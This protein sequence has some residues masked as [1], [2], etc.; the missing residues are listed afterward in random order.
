M[1][2]ISHLRTGRWLNAWTAA[3]YSFFV[4]GIASVPGAGPI[5]RVPNTTLHLPQTPPIF[6][7]AVTNAFGNLAFTAPV[8]I[9]SPPDEI[10]RLFIVEQGGRVSVITNLA[11]PNRTV[12]LDISS[13]IIG[14]VPANEQGL[15]GLAFHPG[16]AS[17]GCFYVYYTGNAT[18]SVAANAPHDIVARYQVSPTNP[19]ASP[20]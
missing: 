4:I 14:G 13:K 6:G 10:N 12:F 1:K 2:M 16:Y 5:Q 17:N 3:W 20:G 9:T 15:L 7:F 8:A 18:T 11:A 19:T